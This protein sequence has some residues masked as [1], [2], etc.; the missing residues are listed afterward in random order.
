MTNE[1]SSNFMQNSVNKLVLL[2]MEACN[3]GDHASAAALL[4]AINRKKNNDCKH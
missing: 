4:D 2:Y 3:K 1:N